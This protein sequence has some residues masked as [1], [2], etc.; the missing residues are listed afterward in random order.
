MSSW[1]ADVMCRLS[2][3]LIGQTHTQHSFIRIVMIPKRSYVNSSR[4]SLSEH[5]KYYFFKGFL[6]Y[7]RCQQK[8]PT[9]YYI[10]LDTFNFCF[11]I[12]SKTTYIQLPIV[13][14]IQKTT[15]PS[16]AFILTVWFSK[17]MY[18]FRIL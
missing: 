16:Y 15:L 14:K 8:C 5:Q 4:H 12:N 1:N 18:D 11:P 13:P 7:L 6:E 9:Y 17:A 3:N 10:P 2:R